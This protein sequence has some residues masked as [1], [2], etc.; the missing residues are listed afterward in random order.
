M[1]QQLDDF[2]L[3]Y[4]YIPIKCD[5]TSTI[6]LNKNP[7]QH[8]ETKHIEIWHQFLKDHVQKGDI[9][10]KFVNTDKQLTDIFI[11]SLSKTCFNFIYGEFGTSNCTYWFCWDCKIEVL[12]KLRNEYYCINLE[13]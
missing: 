6:N 3:H 8:S 9:A 5:N 2:D 7:V 13:S 10:I 12:L 11:K 1:K 4:D